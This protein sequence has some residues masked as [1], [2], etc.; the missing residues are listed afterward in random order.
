M[1]RMNT[2]PEPFFD[3]TAFTRRLDAADE[4]R[5]Q[6]RGVHVRSTSDW[7]DDTHQWGKAKVKG[8]MKRERPASSG[9]ADSTPNT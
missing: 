3:E 5:H 2:N 9:A 4:S 1:T 7:C 8:R 6:S